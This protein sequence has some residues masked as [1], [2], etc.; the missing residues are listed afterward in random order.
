MA[1]RLHAL[2]CPTNVAFFLEAAAEGAEEAARG[3]MEPPLLLLELFNAVGGRCTPLVRVA[4]RCPVGEALL[5]VTSNQAAVETWRQLTVQ[6]T[7]AVSALFF[8]ASALRW[9]HVLNE[10]RFTV[11]GSRVEEEGGAGGTAA[12]ARSARL[13]L[14]LVVT[15]H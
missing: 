3:G 9:R 10:T 7:F 11:Q 14:C 1:V 5:D 12:G 15:T 2:R 8:D 4:L 13:C 6:A